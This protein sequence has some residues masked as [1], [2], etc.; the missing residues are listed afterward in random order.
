MSSP[1]LIPPKVRLAHVD[2]LSLRPGE[3]TGCGTCGQHEWLHLVVFGEHLVATWCD[4]RHVTALPELT[5]AAALDAV[6]DGGL[7]HVILG[8]DGAVPDEAEQAWP[9]LRA[10]VAEIGYQWLRSCYRAPRTDPPPADPDDA[11]QAD[12]R[13]LLAVLLH[14]SD[15]ASSGHPD[16]VLLLPL[17]RRELELLMWV[18]AESELTS[19]AHRMLA[20][21]LLN[22]ADAVTSEPQI[23]PERTRELVRTLSTAAQH[24]LR[25]GSHR[26]PGQW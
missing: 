20:S 9:G 26:T 15:T 21:D 18:L 3:A 4:R 16:D 2:H 11:D 1:L 22:R 8:P 7:S 23:S 24:L 12:L 6:P 25:H 5:A 17:A 19:P 14:G 13:E 10:L